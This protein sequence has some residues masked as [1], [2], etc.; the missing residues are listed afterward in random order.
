MIT[1]ASA[2]TTSTGKVRQSTPLPVASREKLTPHQ[3]N[4]DPM[5][6]LAAYLA[7]YSSANRAG[8]FFIA[9]GFSFAQIVTVIVA[10]LIQSGNDA[11]ALAPRSVVRIIV[12]IAGF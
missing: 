5:G 2:I 8:V 11:A 9:A 7:D 4:W 1:S 3:I 6:I 10:N 12:P